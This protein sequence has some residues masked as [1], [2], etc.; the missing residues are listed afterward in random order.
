MAKNKTEKAVKVQN[1][2]KSISTKHFINL[3]NAY[4][5]LNSLS[6]F[7]KNKLFPLYFLGILL[8]II[9]LLVLVTWLLFGNY[10]VV[11]LS[12]TTSPF[13]LTCIYVYKYIEEN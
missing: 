4:I 12:Q 9:F 2:R 7:I 6:S 13:F 8:C 5:V 3:L 1:L 10:E 11:V